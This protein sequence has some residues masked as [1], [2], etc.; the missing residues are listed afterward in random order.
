M[1]LAPAIELAALVTVNLNPI[2]LTVLRVGN[3][4]GPEIRF[5]PDE[6]ASAK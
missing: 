5:Q 1:L 6:R 4:W 3:S 2:L